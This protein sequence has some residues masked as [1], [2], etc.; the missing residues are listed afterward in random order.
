M[1]FRVRHIMQTI[2]SNASGVAPELLKKRGVADLISV[3]PRKIDALQRQGLP[4]VRLSA[5]C[6][7]YPRQ[8]VLDWLA[9]RTVGVIK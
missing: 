4:H 2:E 9:A 5:R 7:R 8:A 1:V 6:I 3:S